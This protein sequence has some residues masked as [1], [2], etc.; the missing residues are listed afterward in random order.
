MRKYHNKKITADGYTFD[1]TKEYKRFLILADAQKN[2]I[3]SD[4]EVHPLFQLIPK[5]YKAVAKNLK[6]KTKAV[7]RVVERELTYTADFRYVKNGKSV[8]ED[9]KI[10]KRMIP[11]EYIIKRKLMLYFHSVEIREVFKADEP[12]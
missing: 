2:G 7:L 9:V 10:S 8:V 1:S 11:Q 5:Q 6:T 4:L 3:I 12:V